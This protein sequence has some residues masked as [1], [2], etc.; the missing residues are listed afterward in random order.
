MSAPRIFLGD[1][2]SAAGYRLAGVDVRAP[3]PGDEA[4]SFAAALKEARMVLVSSRCAAGIPPAA[5]EA[6]LALISPLVMVVPEWDGTPLASEP[7]NKV[8][9]V[10]GLET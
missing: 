1:E 7:A 8:R 5:L 9:R 10:L 3:S 6:A 2:L 4:A